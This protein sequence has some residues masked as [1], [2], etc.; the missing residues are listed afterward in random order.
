ESGILAMLAAVIGAGLA[1]AGIV[2]FNHVMLESQ[3]YYWMDIRLHPPVLAFVLIIAV[4][5][6]LVSGLLPAMQ[7]ARLDVSAIL[8]DE[9]QAASS[10]RVGRLSRAIVA[11]EIAVSSM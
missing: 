9:S 4:A 1:E 8:K 10:L 7:S 5:A 6:S 3:S 11:V 2:V